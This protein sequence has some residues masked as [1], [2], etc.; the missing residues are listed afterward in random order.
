MNEN[1][2]KRVLA[3]IMLLALV[4]ILSACEKQESIA[5]FEPQKYTIDERKGVPMAA[6]ATN[7]DASAEKELTPEEKAI[8][9]QKKQ[10]EESKYRQW[11]DI[12]DNERQEKEEEERIEED[13]KFFNGSR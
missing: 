6:I 9:W 8:L 13:I 5:N 12:R 7:E 4:L 1:R 2:N 10:E 3:C 11:K